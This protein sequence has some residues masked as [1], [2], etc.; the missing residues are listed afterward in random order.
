VIIAKKF[1]IKKAIATRRIKGS[2]LADKI[3]Y[4]NANM[5]LSGVSC[6]KV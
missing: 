5:D 4:F 1:M 3:A 6:I 2:S